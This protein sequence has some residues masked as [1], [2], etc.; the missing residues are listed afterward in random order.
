L[1]SANAKA[2]KAALGAPPINPTRLTPDEDKV[3]SDLPPS[4]T[5]PRKLEDS[6]SIKR[7][8]ARILDFML[9]HTG[10]ASKKG[11]L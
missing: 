11:K 4:T 9:L 10:T 2:G 1:R 5:T 3:D 6:D 7:T 8:C